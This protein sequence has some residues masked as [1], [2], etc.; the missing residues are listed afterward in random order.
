ME[1]VNTARPSYSCGS[2]YRPTTK[3]EWWLCGVLLTQAALTIISEVYALPLLQ[4]RA[5]LTKE[6]QLYT[7]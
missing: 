6:K 1:T 7:Y 2:M 5:H 4:I 3:Y